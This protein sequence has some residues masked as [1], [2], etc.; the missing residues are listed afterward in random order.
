[1]IEFPT[2]LSR[3]GLDGQYFDPASATTI[4]ASVIN[5]HLPKS[6][7]RVPHKRGVQSARPSLHGM[8]IGLRDH[9]RV[10]GMLPTI[11]Q[12]KHPARHRRF[13]VGALVI[14]V[15]P[16]SEEDLE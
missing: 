1:M 12:I 13:D 7:A 5:P 10:S 2:S 3:H 9:L 8:P 14:G 15:F 4:V 11:E 16:T 6:I